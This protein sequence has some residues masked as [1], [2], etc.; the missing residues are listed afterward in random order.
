MK[1]VF[2]ISG[3]MVLVLFAFAS[4]GSARVLRVSS[5][6]PHCNDVAGCVTVGYDLGSKQCLYNCGAT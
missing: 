6:I 2:A 3:S 5:V 1:R 4:N